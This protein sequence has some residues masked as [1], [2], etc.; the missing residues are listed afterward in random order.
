[1]TGHRFEPAR[2]VLGL[3]L[4]GVALMYVLDAAGAWQ[5]PVR[6][7]LA[8][9]PA[10]LVAAA[11]AACTTFAVRRVLRRRRAGS[12]RALGGMP[13]EGPREGFE[14]PGGVSGVGSGGGEGL[15]DPARGSG[16]GPSRRTGGS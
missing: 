16:D 2:L 3:L 11:F 12:P 13:G 4:V 5:V 6:V 10:S 9:V 14:R 8:V 15:G 1:M 7:L